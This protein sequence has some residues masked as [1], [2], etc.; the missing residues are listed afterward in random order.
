MGDRDILWCC[1]VVG[2][3]DQV[4]G[5]GDVLESE[6]LSAICAGASSLSAALKRGGEEN[7]LLTLMAGYS[8]VWRLR[9]WG[10]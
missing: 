4:Y 3:G 8:P 5:V 2:V 10:F 1:G 7:K 9:E 6:F